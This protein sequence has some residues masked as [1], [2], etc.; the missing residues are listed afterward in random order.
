MR[1]Q[2]AL[3]HEEN[4][5]RIL[6]TFETLPDTII[7]IN[8]AHN[9]LE[10]DA[11]DQERCLG[12]LS[13][14]IKDIPALV[15]ILLGTEPCKIPNVIMQALRTPLTDGYFLRLIGYRKIVDFLLLK[16]PESSAIEEILLRWT[17]EVTILKEH[18]SKLQ[19]QFQAKASAKLDRI[20]GIETSV[21]SI[22]QAVNA[23][24]GGMRALLAENGPLQQFIYET[25]K[26]A[27]SKI[28]EGLPDYV[29]TTIFADVATIVREDAKSRL[30][31]SKLEN[32]LERKRKRL[33]RDREAFLREREEWLKDQEQL[34]ARGRI[35]TH[36]ETREN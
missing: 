15:K 3:R 36:S 20:H 17:R 9:L 25:V 27:V 11:E 14:L 30:R 2:A 4:R 26:K 21:K 13:M 6:E 35:A 7:T 24:E 22:E 32:D 1:I 19:I 8:T 23:P 31:D 10:P 16:I 5:Q 29:R 18:V 12:F 34:I 33:Y 28:P